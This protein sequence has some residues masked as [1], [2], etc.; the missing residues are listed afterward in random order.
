MIM[1]TDKLRAKLD[2]LRK[3]PKETEWVEF[4]HNY[5]LHEEIGEYISALSNSACLHDKKNAY[6]VYGI[7]NETHNIVGTSFNPKHTNV[8]SEELENWFARL[9]NPRID[10]KI[11]EL[12][13]DNLNIVLFRIDPTRSTPVR[14]KETAYIRVGSYKKKLS[15]F[16]EK[17]RKIWTKAQQLHD[18]SAQICPDASISDLAPNAIAKAREEY[19]K[20]NQP[21]TQEINSW[22]DEVFLN[23]AKITIEGKITNTAVI[24]LGKEESEHFIS[25][26]VA[27]ITWILKNEKN[28]NKDYIHF[29]PPFILNSNSVFARIRNLKYRYLL[30]GT[31]FPT[32][33]DKYEPYVI[34]E[35][36][37]NCIA[38]ADYELNESIVVEEKPEELTFINAGI[39]MPGSVEKVIQENR[40]QPHRNPFLATAMLNLGMIDIIGSGIVRMFMLQKERSFPLPDYDLSNPNKVIL[41]ISGK[42]L[43]EKYTRMLM[44]RR[45]LDLPTIILLDRIQKRKHISK[46]QSRLLKSKKLVEGRYP[47]LFVTSILA[48]TAEEKAKYIKHKAIDD[49]HYKELILELI[50]KFGSADRTEIDNLLIEKLPDVLTLEQRRSKIHNLLYAMAMK[51]KTIRN[52]G[53]N[54]KPKWILP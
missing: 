50:R 37:H 8:G 1:N 6:L 27:K 9:L 3:L 47:N 48:T 43:D 53:S 14:F 24:L 34:R 7:E 2:E 51:D 22:S 42:V 29:G 17:E 39:F 28:E 40:P 31:L 32:E 20:K 36:L 4:K 30:G 26:S 25:P 46:E 44:E 18:W 38:H 21:K 49:K 52:S 45:D 41:N 5:V 11:F 35:A 13:Y 54:R 15:D 19:N 16:P 10:F 23:K 33:I 12:L